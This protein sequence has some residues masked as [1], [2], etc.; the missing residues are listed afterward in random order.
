MRVGETKDRRVLGS[1]DEASLQLQGIFFEESTGTL[2][3]AKDS[4]ARF[5]YS[6]IENPVL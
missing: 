6:N 4:I 3:Q 5:I 2:D 1:M